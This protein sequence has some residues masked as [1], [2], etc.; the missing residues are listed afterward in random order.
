MGSEGYVFNNEDPVHTVYLDAFWMDKT[1][2]TNSMYVRCMDAGE[3]KDP[4]WDIRLNAL[5]YPNRP[6]PS[7]RTPSSKTNPSVKALRSWG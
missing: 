5:E 4:G 7:Y 2:V 6:V 3:C 1:E